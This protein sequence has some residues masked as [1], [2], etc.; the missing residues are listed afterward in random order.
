V[1]V[2]ALRYDDFDMSFQGIIER[3]HQ[4]NPTKTR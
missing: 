2:L 4:D 1:K 3:P